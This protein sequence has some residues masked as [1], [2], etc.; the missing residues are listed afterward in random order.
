MTTASSP[1]D[2]VRQFFDSWGEQIQGTQGNVSA[3]INALEGEDAYGNQVDGWKVYNS[4]VP[5]Q[6]RAMIQAG[7]AQMNRDVPLYLSGYL[8]TKRRQ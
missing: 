5:D 3:F 2:N 6:W 7:I 4:A 8:L 1:M